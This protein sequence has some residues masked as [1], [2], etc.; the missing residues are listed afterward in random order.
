VTH[1][2]VLGA[3]GFLGSSLVRY[4]RARGHQCDSLG[5]KNALPG[6]FGNV[7]FCVGA[8]AE[9]HARPFDTMDAHVS[10]LVRLLRANRFE[11]LTYLS[12][13][14]VYQGLAVNAVARE[15]EPLTGNPN[16]PDELY[17]F[18]KLAG[19]SL[20]LSIQNPAI[21]VVRLSNVIGFAPD[22]N[23]LIP[24]L[25]KSAM[26]TGRL[27]LSISPQSS[28]DYIAIDDVLDLLSRIALAGKS[29]C[30]NVASGINVSLGEV[31]RVIQSEFPSACEWRTGAPTISFPAIDI[32]RIRT[33][34]SFTPRSAVDALV[35][36]CAEFRRSR[37][38]SSGA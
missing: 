6:R 4:L 35:S 8:G 36:T 37:V 16:D 17:N 9:F 5:R 1:Y 31:V 18:S 7:M 13:T 34:F 22:G 32:S 20:C 29:R 26:S 30:Y 28:K 25:I 12:S 10:L 19:E 23:S 11:S 14:R 3:E 21:R 38:M 24:A 27:R 33:E 2:S 15:D